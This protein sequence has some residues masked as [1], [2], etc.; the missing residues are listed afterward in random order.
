MY[1]EAAINVFNYSATLERFETA[2]IKMGR[3]RSGWKGW[4]AV[5]DGEAL[6]GKRIF[7]P[8]PA[9]KMYSLAPTSGAATLRRNVP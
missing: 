1:E 6:R 2:T 7:V 9:R 5:R 4:D 3:Q 8:A